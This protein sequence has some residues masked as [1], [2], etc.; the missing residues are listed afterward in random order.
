[1]SRTHERASATGADG[2]GADATGATDNAMLEFAIEST[3]AEVICC[4]KCAG[5][6]LFAIPAT[7]A[8]HS[9]IVVGERLMRNIYIRRY[10]CTD[11]GYVEEWLRDAQD[12][13]TLKEEY[14]RE[15]REAATTSV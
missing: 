11:C 14:R 6:E 7:P 5:G 12:L 8:E 2:T 9:H 1:V 3:T 10:V 15:Q 13:K 4:G